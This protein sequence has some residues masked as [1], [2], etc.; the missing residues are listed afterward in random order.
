M[1]MTTPIRKHKNSGPIGKWA[2]LAASLAMPL[3]GMVPA[4]SPGNRSRVDLAGMWQRYVHDKLWE[5]IPVPSSQHPLGFY[6]LRREFLLPALKGN[7]RAI[8]HFDAITYFTRVSVNGEELGTMGPYLPYEFDF[9]AH[10]RE[11]KNQIDVA[12]SDLQPDATG[13]GKDEIAL[14]VNPDWEAHGGII[15]DVYVESGLGLLS[16]TCAWRTSLLAAIQ[17]LRAR[18]RC[19]SRLQPGARGTLRWCCANGRRKSRGWR[20]I[21]RFQVG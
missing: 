20:K 8:V 2:S 14:G 10:V 17:R 21:F 15:R 16:T 13:A 12:I 1:Q 5:I 7:E 9:T 4:T 3:S 19:S 11:G 6:C 18:G